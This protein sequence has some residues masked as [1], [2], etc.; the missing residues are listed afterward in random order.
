M[1]H[2]DVALYQ[3]M[4]RMIEDKA[5]YRHCQQNARLLIAS[6]YKQ[7]DVWQATLEMY[8]SLTGDDK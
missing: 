2:D 5:L 6:R 1:R 7:E 4:K 8:R 3:A